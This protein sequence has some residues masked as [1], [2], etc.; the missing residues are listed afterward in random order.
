MLKH[1]IKAALAFNT[2]RGHLFPGFQ[3]RYFRRAGTLS[4]YQ[5]GTLN[6]S[7]SEEREHGLLNAFPIFFP[8]TAIVVFSFIIN[9]LIKPIQSFKAHTIQQITFCPHDTFLPVWRKGLLKFQFTMPRHHNGRWSGAERY[10]RTQTVT[11]AQPWGDNNNRASLHNFWRSQSMKIAHQYCARIG[12]K[13]DSHRS[14]T[15]TKSTPYNNEF[16]HA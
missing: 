11:S 10:N 8:Y 3:A 7:L 15:L 9:G 6:A 4:V 13:I 14:H 1:K 16:Y 12:M 2:E 5:T